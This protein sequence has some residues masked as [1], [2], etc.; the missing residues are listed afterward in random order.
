MI[1]SDRE[2]ICLNL[3]WE[4]KQFHSQ[5]MMNAKWQWVCNSK[6]LVNV[7]LRGPPLSCNAKLMSVMFIIAVY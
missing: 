5:I 1:E 6:F 7:Q 4:D 3:I 2:I